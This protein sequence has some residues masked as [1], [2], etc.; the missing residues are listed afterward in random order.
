MKAKSYAEAFHSLVKKRGS[1]CDELAY[2]EA[3]IELLNKGSLGEVLSNPKFSREKKLL[4]LQKLKYSSP[5][6]TQFISFLISKGNISILPEILECY[7]TL[8]DKESRVAKV[9]AH[10]G[11]PLS[12]SF[13]KELI[14]TISKKIGKEIEFKE[15]VCKDLLGGIRIKVDDKV[16][17]GTYRNELNKILNL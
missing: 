12:S 3:F 13:K 15:L 1:S 6:V 16:L 2:L 10:V 14:T 17:D 4:I 7:R 11:D 5:L 8:M 9:E